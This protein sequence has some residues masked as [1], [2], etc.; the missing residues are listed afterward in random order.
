MSVVVICGPMFA[1]KTLN[2]IEKY[3]DANSSIILKPVIDNRYSEKNVVTHCGKVAPCTLVETSWDMDVIPHGI[4]NVLLDEVQ[5]MEVESTVN[6]VVRLMQ[7]G[8][9]VAAAGLDQDS[10]GKPFETTCM[11]MGLADTVHKIKGKCFV[12]GEPN[13]TMTYRK[14]NSNSDRVAVGGTEMYECRCVQHWME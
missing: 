10:F 3:N 13:A 1:G 9:N 12:C 4:H 14:N 6:N 11:L 5:F 7:K 8:I 2:L